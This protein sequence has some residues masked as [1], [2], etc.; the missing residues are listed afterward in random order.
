MV[1]LLCGASGR[2]QAGCLKC[3]VKIPEPASPF[4]KPPFPLSG[5]TPFQ[6]D[7]RASAEGEGPECGTP[8]K[9]H[10][11]SQK[12]PQKAAWAQEVRGARSA[13]GILLCLRS[14]GLRWI[15]EGRQ[16]RSHTQKD[17]EKAKR[18]LLP[19]STGAG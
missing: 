17:L 4:L 14:R 2:T 12:D 11:T 8:G 10:I 6:A 18:V 19:H 1:S 5:K 13:S 3:E 16:W 7:R 15:G 9:P